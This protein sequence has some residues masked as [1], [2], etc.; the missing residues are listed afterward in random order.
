MKLTMT[1][2]R[3][4]AKPLAKAI[5]FKRICFPSKNSYQFP[6]A[7]AF[8]GSM[9]LLYFCLSEVFFPIKTSKMVVNYLNQGYDVF[10][11]KNNTPIMV[12]PNA[13]SFEELQIHVDLQ[14]EK[15]CP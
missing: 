14:S 1:N 6:L 5:G 12:I 9:H 11:I 8:D 10:I 4:L 13:S 2:L 15:L 3:K 7:I